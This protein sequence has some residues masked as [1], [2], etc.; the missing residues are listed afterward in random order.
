MSGHSEGCCEVKASKKSTNMKSL[1][2]FTTRVNVIVQG[3]AAVN[4]LQM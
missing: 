2:T 3:S 1:K 4:Q